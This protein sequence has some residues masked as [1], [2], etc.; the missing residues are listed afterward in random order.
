M[1]RGRDFVKN[2]PVNSFLWCSSFFYFMDPTYNFLDPITDES[3]EA[4]IFPIK[5]KIR[6]CH[7]HSPSLHQ[8]QKLLP[9]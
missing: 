4:V 2:L 1:V 7:F 5:S 3:F 6:N 9:E 8:N